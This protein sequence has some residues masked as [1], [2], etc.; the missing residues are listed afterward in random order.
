MTR[1]SYGAA[2]ASAGVGLA[3]VA[4]YLAACQRETRLPGR[5][6]RPCRLPGITEELEC[7]KLT[8]FENRENHS[9]R[10]IDLNI[11]VLPALDPASKEEPLFDLAG[12]PGVASTAGAIFY[13]TIGKDYRRHREI[14][15]VDQRGTGQ[16][17]SLGASAKAKTPQDFLTEMYPVE[18]VKELRRSL[19]PH[20]DLT[21][22]TTSI[23]MDDLDDVRAWLGYDRINLFGL[24]YGTT[25]ALVYLRQHPEHVR[26]VVLMSVAPVDFKMPL[27]HAEAAERA[28]NLVLAQCAHDAACH[29]AFPEIKS[30]WEKV[31]MDLGREP[32]H[33]MY[34]SPKEKSPLPVT[35]ARNIFTEKLRTVMYSP[36]G[37]RRVPRIIHHAAGG[38][39]EPFL[40]EAIPADRS[41]PDFI[42]DGMYLSVTCTEDVP[43]INQEAAAKMNAGNPFDNY[44][45]LQQTRACSLWPRGKVPPNYFDP[46]TAD[47]PVLII[48]GNV[49]PVTPPDFATEV[50]RHLPNSRQLIIPEGGHMPDGLIHAECLDRIILDFLAKGNVRDIDTTCLAQVAAPP[51]ATDVTK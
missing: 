1:R 23:A 38:D 51:F 36:E 21:Q 32:A 41:A 4:I 5:R 49:D 30:D 35:I 26:S 14:V 24:S 40:E 22:Y 8:V 45:V 44:R 47:T 46:V 43:L 39:F 31:V 42:S 19:E 12:G 17:N 27:R 50:A 6:L 29:A 13:A 2:L 11:V 18:Y 33:A 37:A 48:S 16:S 20:A 34:S 15:L 25:A 10:T 7:G 9:G 3:L 28:L